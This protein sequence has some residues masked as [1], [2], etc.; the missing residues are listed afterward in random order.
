MKDSVETDSPARRHV[1]PVV[2]ILLAATMA[3]SSLGIIIAN[4]ET[5]SIHGIVG[6]S[7]MNVAKAGP[8]TVNA[9]PKAPGNKA[10]DRIPSTTSPES[11]NLST[12]I[13]SIGAIHCFLKPESTRLAFD[14]KNAGLIRTARLSNPDRIYIDLQNK[15]EDQGRRSRPFQKKAL[16]INGDLVS[17]IRIAPKESDTTRIVIDLKRECEFKYQASPESHSQL[18]VELFRK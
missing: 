18:V 14:L 9:K 3:G 11:I 1:A 16:D 4:H 6:A 12:G 5:L 17:R 10:P 8:L 7:G 2:M 15:R 13:P